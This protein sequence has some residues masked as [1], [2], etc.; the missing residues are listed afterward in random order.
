MDQSLLV[1]LVGWGKQ[2]A[3]AII[4]DGS[5][6]FQKIRDGFLTEKC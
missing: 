5:V 4:S 6:M 3:L 2:L 1:Y